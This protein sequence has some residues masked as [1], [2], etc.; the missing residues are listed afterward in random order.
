L[1]TEGNKKIQQKN[2]AGK[3][4]KDNDGMASEVQQDENSEAIR[5]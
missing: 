2:V 1:Y 4:F 5:V 3:G